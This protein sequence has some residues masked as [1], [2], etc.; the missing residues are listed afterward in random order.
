MT[1]PAFT[2]IRQALATRLGSISGLRVVASRNAVV[3]PPS[4]VVMP[5]PGTFLRYSVTFDGQAD[6]V[7]RVLLLVSEADSASGQDN[8]D[9]YLATTGPSSVW[10]AVQAD[11]TLGGVVSGAAVMEASAYGLMNWNGVDYLSCQFT[12]AIEI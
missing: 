11:P 1:Q 12:V 8:L 10:A 7:L 6:P 3:N 4:A 2:A 5:G 9:P